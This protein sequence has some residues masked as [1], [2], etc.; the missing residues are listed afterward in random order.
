VLDDILATLSLRGALYFRTDFSPPWGVCVPDLDG[1]ARFHLVVSGQCV[2]TLASGAAV[3]L[4][5]GDLIMIPGGASHVLADRAGRAAAPLETVLAD[6]G[7]DGAGVLIVG[8]GDNSATTQMVCG[9]FAFRRG[10]DHP[11]LRALPEHVLLTAAD[12]A[13]QPMLDDILRL[14]TKRIFENA[15]GSLAT[16]AR[17]SEAAFIELVRAS[18]AQNPRIAALMHAFEDRQIS[19]A[20]KV[21]HDRPDAS[22]TVESLACEAG[23]SRSRFAERFRNLLGVAPMAYLGEWR[24]QKAL[25]LLDRSRFSVQQVAV[26]SG[27]QSPAAFTRAFAGRFGVPPTEYRRVLN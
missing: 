22:W 26:Q 2:V 4:S 16:V 27:Y 20:L 14:I 21:I 13:R 7:Y 23:M 6:V 10:A 9:H 17:M 3:T 11:L 12:R 8:A 19:R 5:A 15:P 18:V 1:A 25:S 24:L